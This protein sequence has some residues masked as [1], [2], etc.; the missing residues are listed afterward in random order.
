MFLYFDRIYSILF[1]FFELILYIYKGTEL[2]Y[3]SMNLSSELVGVFFF[4]IIQMIRLHLASI[5]NK[6][7]ISMYLMYSI[8]LSIPVIIEYV[9]YLRFQVYCL[10]F[11]VSLG[12]IGLV[13]LGVEV[14]VS[15]IALITI[16]RNDT[17]S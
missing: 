13:F 12:C 9:F 4:I 5:G 6:T 16:R 7:E 1:F 8:F 14:I 11:D 3:P 2:P 10:A 17:E 15:I